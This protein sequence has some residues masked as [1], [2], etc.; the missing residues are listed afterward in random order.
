MHQ[1]R[2]RI[3]SDRRT[4]NHVI[5]QHGDIDGI[6][7]AALAAFALPAAQA[8]D[9]QA[10]DWTVSIGGN[11]NAFYTQTDCKQPAGTVTGTALGDAVLACAGKE[12]TTVIGNGLLPSYLSVGAKSRQ[13]G[14]DVSANVGIGVSVATGSSIAQNNDVDVRQAYLS[15]GNDGMGTVKLGRDYGL[16]GFHSIISDMT[17]IGVGAATNATQNGRVSLGHI[18]SGY[19]F[20][21]MY[22]Q[23]VYTTPNMGGFS[24]DLGLMSPTNNLA[25]AKKDNL[26]FQARATYAGQGFKAWV[27][28]KTQKYDG[29]GGFTMNAGEVGGSVSAGAFGLL[30]NY[31]GGKGIGIL[32][33]GDQGGVK[34]NNLLLQGTMQAAQNVKLGL[35]YGRSKN[36]SAF[37]GSDL[38]SNENLTAGVYYNLTKSVTLVGEIGQTRSKGFS[39]ASAKQN[40]LAIGGILFF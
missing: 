18:G 16:F 31:Q 39:G 30:A 2:R 1:H 12:K 37:T 19:T 34:G 20:P 26:Q 10:G 14:F 23:A 7:A 24:V 8:V 27:G 38:R 36:D 28:A 17:L 4:T 13:G 32:A 15:F 9:I 35:G 22:G 29:V 5:Y 6:A 40:S 25:T 11:V 3:T 33:D 21:G